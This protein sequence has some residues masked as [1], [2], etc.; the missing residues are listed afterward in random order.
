M[1]SAGAGGLAELGSEAGAPAIWCLRRAVEAGRDGG[2]P[3][4]A[5]RLGSDRAGGAEGIDA[6]VAA[7][8]EALVGRTARG[9][10]A[11]GPT[12]CPR[13]RIHL[14][15]KRRVFGSGVRAS[16]R[17]RAVLIGAAAAAQLRRRVPPAGAGR[18]PVSLGRKG[19]ARGQAQ[20]TGGTEQRKRCRQLVR[21]QRR[22]TAFR[23]KEDTTVTDRLV[24]ACERSPVRWRG[25]RS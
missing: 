13:V 4:G 1:V 12:G 3:S 6:P 18:S 11:G 22:R 21:W 14:G 16:G 15:W 20:M 9:S 10:G 5:A 25:R 8:V 2:G 24:A 19:A 7:P 17:R 23:N